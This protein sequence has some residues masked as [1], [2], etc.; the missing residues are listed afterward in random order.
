MKHRLF[1]SILFSVGCFF[2]YGKSIAQNADINMLNAI[3]PNQTPT[4]T[5]W[6]ASSKSTYPICIGLPTTLL[7]SSLIYNNKQ[8]QQSSIHLFEALAINTITT[9]SL[10]KIIRRQR[11]YNQ[12]PTIVYPYS[13]ENDPSFPSGHTSSAFTL[14]T[15]ICLEQK[16]WYFTLP[17]YAWAASVGYSRIYLGEHYPSDVL[18]GAAVGIASAYLTRWINKKLILTKPSHE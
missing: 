7:L 5:F 14:A 11:P 13:I 2:L 16:K 4:A 12:Y 9:Q 15:N 17:A 3:N 6:K 1:Y 8:L 18:A 10:K